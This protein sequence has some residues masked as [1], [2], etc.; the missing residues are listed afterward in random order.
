MEALNLRTYLQNIEMIKIL[1]CKELIFRLEKMK[2]LVLLAALALE[3]R[4][5]F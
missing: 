3:N 1:Y 2:K 5:F 4:Q